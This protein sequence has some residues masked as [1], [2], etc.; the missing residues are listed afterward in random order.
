MKK[1][2]GRLQDPPTLFSLT[3][4]FLVGASCS[5]PYKKKIIPFYVGAQTPASSSP[6]AISSLQL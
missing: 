3:N 4:F 2:L 1:D 5:R 6:P